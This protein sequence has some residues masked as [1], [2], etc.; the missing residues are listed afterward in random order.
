MYLG[1]LWGTKK[2]GDLLLP[3]PDQ[4]YRKKVAVL[5]VATGLPEYIQAIPYEKSVKV[6]EEP[7]FRARSISSFFTRHDLSD[8]N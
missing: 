4:N 6:S 7:V 1:S 8:L 2:T 5:N 3:F